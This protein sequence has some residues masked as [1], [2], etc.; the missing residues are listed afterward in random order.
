MTDATPGQKAMARRIAEAT[1]IDGPLG[2]GPPDAHAA[3]LAA[4][5]ETQ[6]LCAELAESLPVSH[7]S[8][9][10]GARQLI[11]TTIRAGK[12]YGKDEK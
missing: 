10:H 9:P 6:R 8:G 5:I 3:A 4:I 1:R 12:H 11:A 2:L 7:C